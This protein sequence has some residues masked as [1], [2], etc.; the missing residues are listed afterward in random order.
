ML[1]F[2][3]APILVIMPLSFNAEPYFSYPMPGL[4][5]RWYEDFFS[6]ERW[7]N[8]LKTSLII[9]FCVTVLRN[10]SSAPSRRSA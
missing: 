2:L 3:I 8:A 5:L 7:M 10:R 1:L 4:S 9:A 6:N